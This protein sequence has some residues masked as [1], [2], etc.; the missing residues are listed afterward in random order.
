[1]KKRM[2]QLC[3]EEICGISAVGESAGRA[4]REINAVRGVIDLGRC[5]EVI[6]VAVV[7]H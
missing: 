6:V 2:V 4:G 1:M 5:V 7:D 3:T